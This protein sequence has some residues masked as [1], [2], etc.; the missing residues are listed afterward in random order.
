MC[1]GRVLWLLHNN[2][3]EKHYLE[4]S[5]RTKDKLSY[6]NDSFLPLY[7]KTGHN[8]FCCFFFWLSQGFSG[9]ILEQCKHGTSKPLAMARLVSVQCKGTVGLFSFLSYGHFIIG[10]FAL[11]SVSSVTQITLVPASR[12]RWTGS[13][14]TSWNMPGH[15]GGWLLLTGFLII[16]TDVIA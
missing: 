3:V 8:V 16:V 14:Y 6:L 11:A 9:F 13:D 2:S 12:S 4:L 1:R 10:L 5:R 15:K 7:M